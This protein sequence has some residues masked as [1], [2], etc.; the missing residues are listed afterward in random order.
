MYEELFGDVFYHAGVAE[1]DAGMSCCISCTARM[2]APNC[3]SGCAV[4]VCLQSQS[5][6]SIADHEMSRNHKVSISGT[7]FIYIWNILNWFHN[8]ATSLISS[9]FIYSLINLLSLLSCLPCLLNSLGQ[10]KYERN[11]HL[12]FFTVWWISKCLTSLSFRLNA[13]G[14][15][16]KNNRQN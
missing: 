1:S 9:S 8:P 7:R 2:D 5:L 13:A 11:G 14:Q 6:C 12:N 10:P 4:L 3:V 16:W 15:C